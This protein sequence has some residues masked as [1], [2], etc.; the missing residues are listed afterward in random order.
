MTEYSIIFVVQFIRVF[1]RAAQ[2]RNVVWDNYWWVPPFSLIMS[3]C[4]VITILTVVSIDNYWTIIPMFI[5][6]TLGTWFGMYI[7]RRFIGNG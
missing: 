6:G 2:Q 7:H 1:A 3:A 4:D 5:A